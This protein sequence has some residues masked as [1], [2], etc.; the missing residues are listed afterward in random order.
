MDLLDNGRRDQVRL[1]LPMAIAER[2]GEPPAAMLDASTTNEKTIVRIT[3]DIQTSEKIQEIRSPT[4]P[5]ITRKHHKSRSGRKSDR[6]MCITWSSPTFLDKDFVLTVHALGLDKPRCFAEIDPQDRHTIAMQLSLVP[7]F[8]IPPLDSQEYIFVIDR[9]GSMA[10]A[11]METAKRTLE[12][13]LRLLPD[14]QT[15]FN[16]F[17]FGTHVDGLWGKSVSFDQLKMEHAV[18]KVGHCSE[19]LADWHVQISSVKDM[20][21]NYKGTEIA[22]ALDFAISSRNRNRPTAMFVLTDG[23]IHVRVMR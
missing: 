3:V 22:K 23:D 20:K 2:Y 10:G 11:P 15:T 8:K 18:N 16:I 21:A 12:M 17:S 13:L 4:H 1:Q 7:N 19:Q 5:T 9:S 6:W 14:S